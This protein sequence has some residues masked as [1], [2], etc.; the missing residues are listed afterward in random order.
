MRANVPVYIGLTLPYPRVPAQSLCDRCRRPAWGGGGGV[1]PPLSEEAVRR[2]KERLSSE[3][4]MTHSAW[5]GALVLAVGS[6][7]TYA[8]VHGSISI[9]R[10][11]RI[12]ISSQLTI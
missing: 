6:V 10:L 3:K 12:F 7:P 2:E 4:N 9:L 8:S 5:A 1:A 11:L